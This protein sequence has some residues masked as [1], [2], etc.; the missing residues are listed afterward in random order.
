MVLDLAEL[1]DVALQLAL[2]AAVPDYAASFGDDATFEARTNAAVGSER[3]APE[4]LLLR[5]IAAGERRLSNIDGVLAAAVRIV[6]EEAP[7]GADLG[8][9]ASVLDR[10]SVVGPGSDETFVRAGAG[11]TAASAA[12]ADEGQW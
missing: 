5:G 7:R 1:A 2:D 6:L 9:E 12:A 4:A 3:G 10:V 11:A 8:L